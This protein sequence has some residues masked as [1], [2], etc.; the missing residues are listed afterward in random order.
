[1]RSKAKAGAE[2]AVNWVES[3]EQRA[4]N[5]GKE[6]AMTDREKELRGL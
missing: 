2:A 5:E 4:W 1:M 3:L 6:L